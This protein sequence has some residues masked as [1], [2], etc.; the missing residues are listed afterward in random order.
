LPKKVLSDVG[1]IPMLLYQYNRLLKCKSI[2][3]IIIATT[4]STLDDEIASLCVSNNIKYYRGTEKNVLKRF[5]DTARKY[6]IKNIVRCNADCPLIDPKLVDLIVLKYFNLFPEIDYVSNILKPTF[7]LGMHVEIFSNDVLKTAYNNAKKNLEKEH[8][9][10]YIYHNPNKFRL[11]N[12][13]S[14]TNLSNHRF[15]VDY[16]ED[17]LFIR[18]II[19]YFKQINLF[20]NLENIVEYVERNKSIAKNYKYKKSQTV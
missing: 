7:P 14:K 20:P 3:D 4:D 2:N 8:V 11:F 15:T 9:T 5:Y 12:V 18:K 16:K 17:L 10:P 6:D 1:G 19:S 13:E